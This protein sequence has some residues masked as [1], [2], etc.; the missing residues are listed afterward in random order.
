MRSKDRNAHAFRYLRKLGYPLPNVRRALQKLTG[1]K[2]RDI[3]KMLGVTRGN[4]A[5][6]LGGQ[7]SAPAVEEGIAKVLQ[8]PREELFPDEARKGQ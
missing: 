4:V 7:R 5:Q 1:I 6:H 3:A 8:V 2:Q